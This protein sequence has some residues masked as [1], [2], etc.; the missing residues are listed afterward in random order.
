MYKI[1]TATRRESIDLC[2]ETPLSSSGHG[3]GLIYNILLLTTKH[4]K[5]NLFVDPQK[6]KILI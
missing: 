1:G 5:E 2:K 3:Y 4:F 6:R